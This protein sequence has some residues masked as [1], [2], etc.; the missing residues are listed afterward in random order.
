MA[1]EA[2]TYMWHWTYELQ[3]VFSIR[4]DFSVNSSDRTTQLGIS[5]GFIGFISTH[6][7]GQL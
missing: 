5:I 7:G 2:V 6:D 1:S 4:Q 3:K